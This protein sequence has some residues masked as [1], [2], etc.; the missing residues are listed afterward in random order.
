MGTKKTGL[1]ERVGKL[2][3]KGKSRRVTLGRCQSSYEIKEQGNF[4]GIGEKE[5]C[6]T[7]KQTAKR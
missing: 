1:E 7:A 6:T 5:E 2:M 3:K 4:G